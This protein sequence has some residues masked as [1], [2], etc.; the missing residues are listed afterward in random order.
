MSR[1]RLRFDD[2]LQLIQCQSA[3]CTGE[4]G[5][6]EIINHAARG[7]IDR[8]VLKLKDDVAVSDAT[9]A[10]AHIQEQHAMHDRECIGA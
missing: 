10:L 4:R 3:R 1:K 8:W 2:Q 5:E 7:D 9:F 6:L